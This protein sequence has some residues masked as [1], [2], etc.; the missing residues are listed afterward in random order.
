MVRA[1][2]GRGLPVTIHRINTGPHSTTG[3]FNRADYLN[4]LLKGC[5]EAGVAPDD[6]EM[7]LQPAPIDYVASAVVE[8]S[9]RPG[10]HGRAFHLVN[11]H[12]VTW[13]QFYDSVAGFGYALERMPFDAWRE[14]ITGRTSGTVA[15]L[16][17]VPFLNDAIDDVR[18][19]L[20]DSAQTR[21][22]LAGTGLECPAL[23]TGL[24]HTFLRRF[25]SERFVD[26]PPPPTA[27]ATARPPDHEEV[28]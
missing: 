7:R 16:G 24:V 3:A 18:L 15:L 2:H 5:I 28:S 1:A 4:M 11:H 22:A 17:L 19:P 6:L 10:L 12:P 23:D 14:R 13:P 26:P 27:R 21:L 20:S 25:V 9:S 8:L